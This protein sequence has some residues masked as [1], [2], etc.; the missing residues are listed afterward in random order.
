MHMHFLLSCDICADQQC[1]DAFMSA[2]VYVW[3]FILPLVAEMTTT[4]R[5][6]YSYW[7]EYD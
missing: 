6:P 3:L 2:S 4:P 1:S 7:T 5:D